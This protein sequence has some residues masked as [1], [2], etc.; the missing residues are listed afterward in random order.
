MYS[1]FRIFIVLALLA[2]ALAHAAVLEN[3]SNGNFYSGVSVISGWKCEANGSLTVRFFDT[4]MTPI[5]DPVPLAYLNERTDTAGVCGDTNNGFVAI[6][7]YARLGRSD[8]DEFFTAV[9]YDNREEF[10]RSTFKVYAFKD[11]FGNYPD[12][13]AN[14]D[15]YVEFPRGAFGS[16]VAYDFHPGYG[17]RQQF[18]WNEATQHMEMVNVSTYVNSWHSVAFLDAWTDPE[19]GSPECSPISFGVSLDNLT[20][21]RSEAE[22]IQNCE[23]ARPQGCTEPCSAYWTE[24][25]SGTTTYLARE[26]LTWQGRACH[27]VFDCGDRDSLLVTLGRTEEH[28]RSRAPLKCEARDDQG[29]G[30]TV[31]IHSTGCPED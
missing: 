31:N 3:P 5:G 17:D 19:F 30:Y 13:L 21:A 6:W 7:N 25:G 26:G 22:A 16:C 28:A 11:H 29:E 23:Q 2:P 8:D 15:N 4:N 10:A 20:L 27:A 18:M 1:P 14:E 9:A 24:K 12:H